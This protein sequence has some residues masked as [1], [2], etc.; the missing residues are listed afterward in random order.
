MNEP[1][2]NLPTGDATPRKYRWPWFFWGAVVLFIALAVFA[3]AFAAHRIAT[4]RDT[5][6]PLP[7]TAPMR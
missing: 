5:N 7:G 1:E 6:A 2:N 4:E 3:V